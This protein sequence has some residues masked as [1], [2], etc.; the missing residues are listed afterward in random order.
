M[1]DDNLR[2]PWWPGILAV[3]HL[4]TPEDLGD[5]RPIL[6]TEYPITSAVRWADRIMR[7]IEGMFGNSPGN[8]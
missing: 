6:R 2:W 1:K 8:D 5:S 4:K 3:R 7:R